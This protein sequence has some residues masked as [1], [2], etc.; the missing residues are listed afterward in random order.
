[1][2]GV[3]TGLQAVTLS[4]TN[5][6]EACGCQEMPQRQ[7]PVRLPQTGAHSIYSTQSKLK[8]LRTV[9][10]LNG[11]HESQHIHM[12]REGLQ[13]QPPSLNSTEVSSQ[14]IAGDLLVSTVAAKALCSCC[15]VPF[16][17]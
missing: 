1:M 11:V 9:Q 5:F 12:L 6:A 2:A 4:L 15:T 16:S 3:P 8:R 17:K 7:P 14:F 13:N 10:A